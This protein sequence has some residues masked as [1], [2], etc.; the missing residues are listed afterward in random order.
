MSLRVL[1]VDDEPLA[2]QRLVRLLAEHE[3]YQIVAEAGNGHAA[4]DW[5]R[6]HK[7]DLILLDIEMPGLTGLEVAEQLM[8]IG[9]SSGP[10]PAVI[11]CT[12]YDEY[13]F[14][15]FKVDVVDYLLK[16][17][18]KDDLN[19]ALQKAQRWI[20]QQ[21][22]AEV[23]T[24]NTG[25]TARSHISARTHQGLQLIPVIDIVS[26]QADQ[27]YITVKYQIEDSRTCEVLIDEPLKVLEDEFEQYF[28]RI[29]RNA[30]VAKG[31]I[32]R[33]ETVASSVHRLYLKGLS[34]GMSVSRRHLP[35]VRKLMRGL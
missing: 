25:I 13:A 35:A 34:E 22:D 33:L 26:F 18:R 4:L 9:P 12:A 20:E 29:H 3:H 6:Q 31:K 5:L 10:K 30:L 15:A 16:P 24:N 11:F 17:I 21:V 14:N 28:V 2:R 19:K 8:K 23:D 32:D 27:K 7:A 1:L